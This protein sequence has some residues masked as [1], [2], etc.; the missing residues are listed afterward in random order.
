MSTKRAS[1]EAVAT[2]FT[3]AGRNYADVELRVYHDAWA[4]LSDDELAAAVRAVVREVDLAAR[5]PS[6][7]VVRRAVLD[8]RAV[9]AEAMRRE[10]SLPESTEPV[11]SPE[12]SKKA[13]AAIRSTFRRSD[14]TR[15]TDEVPA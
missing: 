15:P 6:P 1:A 11:L 10:R 3:A 2:L 14:G 4:D 9:R 7:A 12:E 8:S 13:L 5:F